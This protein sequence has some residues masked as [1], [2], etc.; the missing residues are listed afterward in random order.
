[1]MRLFGLVVYMVGIGLV[2]HYSCWQLSLGVTIMILG[3]WIHDK[4][5]EK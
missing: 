4:G 2:T 5:A 3:N 1:M